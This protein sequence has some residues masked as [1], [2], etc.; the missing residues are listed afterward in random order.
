MASDGDEQPPRQLRARLIERPAPELVTA[1]EQLEK[2]VWDTS[3]LAASGNGVGDYGGAAAAGNSAEVGSCTDGR[4]CATCGDGAT[5]GSTSGGSTDSSA[6]GDRGGSGGKGERTLSKGGLVSI[7]CAEWVGRLWLG[8]GE[9]PR[10][11]MS[12]TSQVDLTCR[13]VL[14]CVCVCVCVCVRA[15]V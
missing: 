12:D 7:Q 15:C 11:L 14:V 6:I 5:T 8:V 1:L 2:S 10:G 9:H 13:W 3:E 4:T